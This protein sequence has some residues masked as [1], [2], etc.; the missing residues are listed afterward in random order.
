M[1]ALVVGFWFHSFPKQ[2]QRMTQQDKPERDLSKY[3]EMEGL[4]DFDP[5]LYSSDFDP[6]LY[7]SMTSLLPPPNNYSKNSTETSKN[8][9]ETSKNSTETGKE[10]TENDSIKLPNDS[11]KLPIENN[12]IKNAPVE[13]TTNGSATS[14]PIAN[15]STL[16]PIQ[17]HSRFSIGDGRSAMLVVTAICII[18]YFIFLAL[19][20]NM[21][22][23]GI[24]L[25]VYYTISLLVSIFGY[26]SIIMHNPR[27]ILIYTVSFAISAI[28]SLLLTGMV[29]ARYLSTNMNSDSEDY[30]IFK[31]EC[32]AKS[33]IFVLVSSLVVLFWIVSLLILAVF[34]RNATNKKEPEMKFL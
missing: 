10:T 26:Y 2:K 24:A 27:G 33:I 34:Y 25:K 28:L 17:Q 21:S 30:C 13:N 18:G 15:C 4:K 19:P 1:G 8:S 32:L 12:E 3:L 23:H 14:V 5:K 20:S 9:T 6:K 16:T 7:S 11:I 22:G 31:S 29:L